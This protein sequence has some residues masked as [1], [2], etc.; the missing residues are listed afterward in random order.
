MG[1]HAAWGFSDGQDCEQEWVQS[2]SLQWVELGGPISALI[3]CSLIFSVKVLHSV[4]GSITGKSHCGHSL[5]LGH[6]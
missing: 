4:T 3:F 2:V 6:I 5:Q 1:A